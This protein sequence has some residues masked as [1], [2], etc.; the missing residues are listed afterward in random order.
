VQYCA[1]DLSAFYF[2]VLKDRLYCD[3]AKGPRRLSCQTALYRVACDLTRLMAP[4]LP[5]TADEV[6][7]LLPG[8]AATSVHLERFP[9][10]E[11]ADNALLSTW[12]ALAATRSLVTKALE[13]ARASGVIA[14]SL[15]AHVRLCGMESEIAPL[16]RYEQ[17]GHVFP[18]NLANLF[19]VS[20]V[21]LVAADAPLSVDVA[22]APGVKCERCWTYFEG[23]AHATPAL[24]P[25]CG[26][27]LETR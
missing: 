1:A 9:P 8:A 16:R 11:P 6:W 3:P 27:S 17:D 15:E 14:S 21:E 20:H 23:R 19:I 25:R 13:Q 10:D 5:M 12:D 26:N 2:D 22:R 24:C 4:I 7:Q 18:G